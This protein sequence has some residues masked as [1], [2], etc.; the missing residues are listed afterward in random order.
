MPHMIVQSETTKVR[1]SLKHFCYV[2]MSLNTVPF[3]KCCQLQSTN[4]MNTKVN[5]SVSCD[6]LISGCFCLNFSHQRS[7]L[8][9]RD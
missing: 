9:V 8:H 2:Q 3:F 7:N 5:T 4:G 1:F 6:I